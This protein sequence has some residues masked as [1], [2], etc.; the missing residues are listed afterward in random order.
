MISYILAVLVGLIVL[1]AD[2]I[3]KYYIITNF[4]IGGSAE[5]LNGFIDIVFVTNEGGAWGILNGYTWALLSITAILMIICFTLLL[6][7]GKKNKIVFWAMT[8]ILFGGLGNMID[9]IF[10]N[11]SVVDFLH[12]EFWPSFPVFNIADCAVVVGGGL[13]ILYFVIDA[14]KDERNKQKISKSKKDDIY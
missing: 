11:G 5:F 10:R 12:F 7:L 2:Q 8:L 14:I 4:Q 3:S 13:L 9:R 6:K 1:A